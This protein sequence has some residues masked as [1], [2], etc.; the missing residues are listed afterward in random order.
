MKFW[1]EFWEF[2]TALPEARISNILAIISILLVVFIGFL[3]YFRVVND[4]ITVKHIIISLIY[5]PAFLLSIFWMLYYE[6]DEKN[7][8]MAMIP[9]CFCLL[10]LLVDVSI[11]YIKERRI[12]KRKIEM[13]INAVITE[14]MRGREKVLSCIM[15]EI[16]DKEGGLGNEQKAE[17]DNTGCRGNSACCRDDSNRIE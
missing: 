2:L 1:K 7:S 11:R 16:S 17:K 4:K 5:S 12:A 15:P 10:Y 9:I 6:Y 13:Q 8:L 3:I 14:G